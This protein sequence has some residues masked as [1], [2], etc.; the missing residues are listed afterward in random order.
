M[1]LEEN[2]VETIVVAFIVIGFILAL[3]LR[4]SFISYLI[5]FIIGFLAGRT[6][7]IKKHQEPI[8]HVVILIIGFLLGYIIASFWSNRLI[9]FILFISSF[10]LSYYLHHEKII[11]MFKSENFLK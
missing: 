6:F 11:T 7:Y 2:W 10:Y 4:N 8:L 9:S 3:T 5:I 1:K